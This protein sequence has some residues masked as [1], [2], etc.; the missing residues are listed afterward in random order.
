MENKNNIDAL[1]KSSLNGSA[2]PVEV[3]VR[4]A[5]MA[6]ID[7]YEKRKEKFRYIL[8]WVLSVFTAC[9]SLASVYIFSIVFDFY[10]L[11]FLKLDLNP[12]VVRSV[13]QC[14]FIGILLSTLII[15]FINLKSRRKL[16][17]FTF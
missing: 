3:D 4:G 15:M 17:H 9:A 7:A 8:Q 10:E 1:I 11:F 12:V 13:F 14:F 2:P 16:Y 6:R 5:T